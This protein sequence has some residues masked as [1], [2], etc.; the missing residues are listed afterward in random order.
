MTFTIII[1][2]GVLHGLVLGFGLTWNLD[3]ISCTA[4]K[5][6]FSIENFFSKLHQIHSFLYKR[7]LH[8]QKK[9]LMGNFIFSTVV[10]KWFDSVIKILV[11]KPQEEA[12]TGLE[13]GQ[14]KMVT[15]FMLPNTW[16]NHGWWRRKHLISRRS[17]TPVSELIL[18]EKTWKVIKIVFFKINIAIYISVLLNNLGT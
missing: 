4:Q 10:F 2:A 13:F 11:T 18:P 1:K 17:K 8:L 7:N 15:R 9:S 5:M 14:R 3:L 16:P 6:M 12:N